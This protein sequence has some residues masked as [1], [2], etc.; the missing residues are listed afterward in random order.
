MN[1]VMGNREKKVIGAILTILFLAGLHF[2]VF[3][4]K[5]VDY[6]LT[7]TEWRQAK[8]DVEKIVGQA[9]NPN[10]VKKTEERI[11]KNKEEF[12]NIIHSLHIDLPD[13]YIDTSPES[14]KK[15]RAEFDASI[16]RLLSF[17]TKLKNTK[18]SFLGEKGWNLPQGLPENIR[19]RPERLWDVMSQLRGISAILKVIDNQVVR[20][21]KLRQYGDLLKEIG[22]DEL[23]IDSLSKYGKYVPVINLICYYRLIIKE[24]P[25]DLKM[26]DEQI[27]EYLRI[28]YPDNYLH[29]LNRQLF[30]L[31]DIIEMADAN[32]IED[33]TEVQM[34]DQHLIKEIPKPGETPPP[35]EAPASS[36][37]PPD[38]L[39]G[40]GPM[41]PA[42]VVEPE[43]GLGAPAAL[44]R[45]R[46]PLG[47]VEMGEAPLMRV[48]PAMGRPTLVRRP[49]AA[50]QNLI[51]VGM[52]LIIRVNGS[53]FSITNF[54][55]TVCNAPK[56]Y[57][58]DSLIIN[59]IK[60]REGVLDAYAWFNI[61]ASVEGVIVDLDTI[62]KEPKKEE[63]KPVAPGPA[64]PAQVPGVVTPA[65]GAP[66]GAGT[67]PA[68]VMPPAATPVRPGV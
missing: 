51:A 41:A 55:Y 60:E 42:G 15:R 16:E 40:E 28:E 2:M 9:K 4:R 27:Q 50:L 5:A 3:S 66:S 34:N 10:E 21:E 61:L 18:L 65:A 57:E 6:D 13:I 58:L 47:G 36:I 33:I 7:M 17:Q 62:W 31:T 12:K 54:L 53:N 37:V 59:T 23:A 52:P 63:A 39:P 38:V 48:G 24:K 20:D 1:V 25:K 22:I 29:G 45:Q 11:N 68:A 44:G 32:K 67:L 35:G 46:S 14:L 49:E 19:K 30:A 8:E 56:S 43:M 64:V 26:T